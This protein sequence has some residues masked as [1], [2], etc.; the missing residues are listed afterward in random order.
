MPQSQWK[1]QM[2]SLTENID[3]ILAYLL[4]FNA[5][6]PLHYK[7]RYLIPT[8]G[9][10]EMLDSF[11]RFHLDREEDRSSQ[12]QSEVNDIDKLLELI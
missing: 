5:T 9:L 2:D 7:G 6:M 1:Y 3:P 12:N 8:A 11:Q 10:Q 4:E